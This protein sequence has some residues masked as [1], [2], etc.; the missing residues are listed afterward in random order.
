MTGPLNLSLITPE[1]DALYQRLE[2]LILPVMLE[3][4]LPVDSRLRIFSLFLG[5]TIGRVL[6]PEQ[7]VQETLQA[8]ILNVR[9]GFD[10]ARRPQTKAN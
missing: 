1:E 6:A 10:H 4:D 7:I 8:A 9:L 3:E 2:A 5:A